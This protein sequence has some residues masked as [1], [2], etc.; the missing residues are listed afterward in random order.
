MAR[1]IWDD[2]RT[3]PA[4]P[5]D[6]FR[7]STEAG[8]RMKYRLPILAAVCLILGFFAIGDDA[9]D[10]A[11][12]ISFTLPSIVD[13]KTIEVRRTGQSDVV[14]HVSKDWT[15]ASDQAAVDPN[16]QSGLSALF[17]TPI[18]MDY[19]VPASADPGQYGISEH[20]IELVMKSGQ[21][22]IS[23]FRIGKVVDS[24]RTF[25]QD[26]ETGRIYRAKA[27][28]RSLI[29]RPAFDWRDRSFFKRS[30]SDIHSIRRVEGGTS[31][32]HISRTENGAPW[33][34]ILPVGIT[35]GQREADAIANTLATAEAVALGTAESFE[36]RFSLHATTFD[37]S[38]LLLHFGS[39]NEDG[40][41]DAR[42]DAGPVMRLPKHQKIFLLAQAQDL[43]NR[44][45]FDLDPTSIVGL[46]LAGPEKLIL[47]RDVDWAILSPPPR[48]PLKRRQADAFI[49]A[50]LSLKASGF[51]TTA[52]FGDVED[53]LVIRQVDDT[54][55]KL[56]IGA[57]FGKGR[58]ARLQSTPD[59]VFI[60]PPSA[61]QLCRTPRAIFEAQ[62][63]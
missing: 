2:H 34:A 44:R 18:A 40:T 16:I 26:Q 24:R 43:R 35:V 27:D 48:L 11:T 5:G 20:S 47:K 17:S 29:D 58:F 51:G 61:V 56:E 42:V 23:N 39:E 50:I 8:F 55:T 63:D 14:L 41:I 49:E 10:R 57:P 37:Q 15:M 38:D 60:L 19:A 31:Q 25:I 12:Q 13:V 32:W 4:S 3:M 54:I 62:P 7:D 33:T 36:T 52:Q 46:S 1:S 30:F 6:R 9:F 45:I 59:R 53:T 28:L 21:T 22:V